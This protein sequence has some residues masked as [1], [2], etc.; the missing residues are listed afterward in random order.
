MSIIIFI[1]VLIIVLSLHEFGHFIL[2]KIFG[3]RVD[4]FGIG[5]PPR[6]WGK[7]IKN[8]IYSINWLPF[9]AFVKILGED[10]DNENDADSFSNQK[11]WKRL[12]VLFGGIIVN[13]LCGMLLLGVGY[14]IGLPVL[15]NEDEVNQVENVSLSILGV[16]GNSPAELSGLKA[17][18]IV[19]SMK[20]E[21]DEMQDLTAER[22]SEFI[23]N[24]AGQE[25]ILSV[26]TTDGIIEKRVVPRENPPE[27]QGALGVSIGQVGFVQY[28]FFKS[29]WLGIKNGFQVFINTFVIAFYLIKGLLG[30]GPSIGELVGP[31]GITALG[32]Q[33][34]KLGLGYLLQFLA[35]ISINLAAV[36]MIP[37][38]A[39]DGGRI[40]FILIEKI[41]GKPVKAKTE[42]M[43]HAT[44]FALLIALSVYIAVKDIIRLF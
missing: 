3:V 19:L 30:F 38:P 25:V 17:G 40:L 21:G 11:A 35:G 23:K 41:K 15:V 29:I 6:I 5:Y 22:F 31:I 39:L 7:K 4:E 34:V 26:K 14:A 32:G 42:N 2:A 18:D 13:L 36:N 10:R 44:G 8:T 1:I 16:S 33:T 9:G 24:H 37:I 27:G 12:L 43:V 20:S 28:G